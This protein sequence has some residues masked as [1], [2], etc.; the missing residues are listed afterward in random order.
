MEL[1]E[2]QKVWSD[3][4]DQLEK[5]KEL[6]HKIIMEMTKR[7]YKGKFQKFIRYE[8]VG[9]VICLGAAALLILYFY[10]LDTWYFMA[11]G[12]V[13]LLF[14]IG[15]PVLVLR[16]LLQIKSIDIQKG[17]YKEVLTTY[18]QAKK[19]LLSVQRNSIYLSFVFGII[20]LPLAGKLINNKDVF[21]DNEWMWYLPVMLVFLLVFSRWAYKKYVGA[22][23]AAE[24]LLK[25][26]Y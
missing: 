25:E 20:S 15:L 11:M 16:S 6:T 12:L 13:A 19:Q 14:L 18:A 5:Q 9:A 17:S 22:T 26:M 8:G 4:S 21:Q 7:K 2:L 3:L 24:E 23:N 1:D 10:R